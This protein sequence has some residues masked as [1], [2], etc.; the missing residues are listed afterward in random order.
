MQ[1]ASWGGLPNALGMFMLLAA[2]VVLFAP[3]L[4]RSRVLV[5][6]VLLGALPLTHH[7][8]MLTAT[9]LLAVY[10][11]YVLLRWQRTLGDP[12][13]RRQ[14]ANALRRLALCGGVALLTASYYVVPFALRVVV[15][16]STN[17]GQFLDNYSGVIF[18]K[19]GVLLWEL[20]GIGVALLVA[21][22]V[23]RR[24]TVKDSSR[25]A[26]AGACGRARAFVALASVT[27]L[28][29]FL[30]GYYVYG[31][32]NEQF[33][34]AHQP[35]TLFTPTRFLTDLTYFLPFFAALPLVWAWQWSAAQ[36]PGFRLTAATARMLSRSAMRVAV[37]VIVLSTALTLLNVRG[38]EANGQLAP[39]EAE[40]FAW[41]QAHTAANTLVVNLDP[42]AVWA[43]YFTRREVAYTPVPVSEIVAGY[44]TEKRSLT[45]E[46]LGL[47][48][49]QGT[50]GQPR[51][52]AAT[53]VGSA[54]D[55][56]A[57][58]PVVVLMNQAL[59]D[60]VAPV[61][62]AAGP[63][64]VYLLGNAFTRMGIAPP[65]AGVA[66]VLWWRSSLQTPPTGWTD[67]DIGERAG[68]ETKPPND[69]GRSGATYIR[70][71]LAGPLPSGSMIA[72]AAE[73]D[74]AAYLDG[75]RLVGGCGS[76]LTSLP[77]LSSPGPHVVALH[78]SFG[79]SVE[80]W[81]HVLLAASD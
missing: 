78:A 9:L 50:T 4:E 48:G 28:L 81:L 10:A 2:L 57:G 16:G 31:F 38:T 49:A 71:E 44:V 52:V 70:L 42:Q 47:L 25:F 40:A 18:D 61:A 64:R 30:F 12:T 7:H 66:R 22:S 56:L 69:M 63:E 24:Y 36:L 23:Q 33:T 26:V 41:I 6:G 35:Y 76:G 11:G 17:V 29:A 68:W 74:V 1:Y 20:A 59:G 55:A 46:L 3:G 51:V 45:D 73:G 43:P 58:R 77:L 62:F 65:E 8:V 72:C 5:G 21:G 39:G 79:A 15:L 37:T 60:G 80:P 34:P 14:M 75:K 54:L 67:A 27:L 13:L 53:G 19:N 32:Y